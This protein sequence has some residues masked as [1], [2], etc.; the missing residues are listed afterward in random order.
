MTAIGDRFE[1]I[2]T[3]D[4]GASDRLC[5]QT[6]RIREPGED[7]DHLELLG[8]LTTPGCTREQARALALTW[9]RLVWPRPVPVDAVSL[10][11]AVAEP[12]AAER[13]A[14]GGEVRYA[15]V[16]RPRLWRGRQ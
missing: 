3:R 11:W 10:V 9:L 16:R 12:G 4:A 5:Y 6:A 15:T 7:G 1:V 2:V 13:A 8:D 14:V